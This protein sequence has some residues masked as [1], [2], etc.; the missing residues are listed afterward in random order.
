MF[1]HAA[2]LENVDRLLVT[3]GM[4]GDGGDAED[5][6]TVLLREN[7]RNELGRRLAEPITSRHKTDFHIV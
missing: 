2:S 7:R 3:G 6:G 1:L 5:S 4:E